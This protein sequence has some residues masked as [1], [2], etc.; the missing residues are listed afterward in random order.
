[1]VAIETTIGH[2]KMPAVSEI[3]WLPTEQ[4]LVHFHCTYSTSPL[5]HGMKITI[6]VNT[7]WC[8]TTYITF[9]D[10]WDAGRGTKCYLRY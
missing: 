3:F 7:K 1:M 8:P 6:S 9:S 2:G 4:P 10:A 5:T